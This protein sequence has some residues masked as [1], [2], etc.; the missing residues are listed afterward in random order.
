[1]TLLHIL[2]TVT[3]GAVGGFAGCAL[4]APWRRVAVPLWF[5]VTIGV[6]CAVVGSAAAR[7]AGAVVANRTGELLVQFLF[8][9]VGG[10]VM[11][12]TSARHRPRDH[13]S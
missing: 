10:V 13:D 9:A 7:M 5:T 8:A 11:A 12:A 2:G 1:M 6:V 4:I 3:A